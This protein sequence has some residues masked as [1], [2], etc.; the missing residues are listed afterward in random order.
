MKVDQTKNRLGCGKEVKAEAGKANHCG[1]D[2][3]NLPS[4]RQ[5]ESQPK[6]KWGLS[7]FEW[8][9]LIILALLTLWICGSP[10]ANPMDWGHWFFRESYDGVHTPMWTL[11][12]FLVFTYLLVTRAVRSCKWRPLHNFFP[13]SVL[14][15]GVSILEFHPESSA[16][17][18]GMH[19][20]DVIIEYGSERD[21][22]IE[23][24]S[25]IIRKR[26]PE[27]G[28]VCVVFMRGRQQYS[29]TLPCGPLGISVMNVTVNVPLKS[30]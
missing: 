25:A 6:K 24:L 1:P 17:E 16:R 22:T 14:A 13:G 30:E 19:K 27:A 8:L 18:A 9:G 3:S 23:K 10:P 20:G 15:R 21:V 2:P 7:R 28:Q 5:R 12:L 29:N 11:Y 4:K 26:E